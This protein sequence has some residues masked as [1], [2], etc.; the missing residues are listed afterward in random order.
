[1]TTK[2]AKS[3]PPFSVRLEASQHALVRR[4]ADAEM[5]HPSAW[6]RRTLVRAAETEL[7]A[8]AVSLANKRRTRRVED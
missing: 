7:A 3:G 1:M 6:A 5:M 8:H 4:A 2:R